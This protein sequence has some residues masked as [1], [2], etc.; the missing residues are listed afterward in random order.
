[1]TFVALTAFEGSLPLVQFVK[2]DNVLTS[3]VHT[4]LPPNT[5]FIAGTGIDGAKFVDINSPAAKYL[6][7][8]R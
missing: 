6:E 4:L 2:K 7:L 5:Q 3:P 1:M 8:P